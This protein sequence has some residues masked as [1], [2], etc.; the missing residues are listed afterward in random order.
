MPISL[1]ALEVEV[2]GKT[3]LTDFSITT[4]ASGQTALAYDNSTGVF[5]LTPVLSLTD[6]GVTDGL[7]GQ[8]LTTDGS[9]NFS[10]ATMGAPLTAY[11]VTTN[12]AGTAALSYN[13]TNGVFTYTPPDL[14]TL[15]ELTDIQVLTAAAGTSSLTYDNTNGEFIFTPP[16]L[17]TYLTSETNTSLAYTAGSQTLTYTDE[18][19]S[20]TNIDLSG[21]LD[22]TNIVTSV[23]TQTGA[24]VLD[25]LDLGITDGTTGQVLSTDGAGNF[26]FVNDAGGIAFTD[27]SITTA[28][29]GTA[30]LSYN[31][32]NGVFTYTPPD[33]SSYLTAETTTTLAYTSGTQTLTYTDETGS[34][35]NIDLSGLLDDTNLVTSVNTQTGAVVLGLLDLSISDGTAGQILSTDGAG[36]FSFVNDA[37]GIALTDLSVTTATAGTAAL[38]YD[39]STG[40]FTFTPEDISA[41]IELTDLSITTAAAG[42][43]A[44]AYDNSTGV[45]TYTP[46]DL[47]SYLTA[48]SDTLATITARGATTTTAVT[49]QD[50]SITGT[51]TVDGPSRN[52]LATANSGT[53]DMNS[54]THFSCTPAS[55]LTLT[56]TNITDGQSGN[57]YFDNSGGHTITKAA[58]VKMNATGL[59]TI[60][61]AGVFWLSYFSN[62]TDVLLS[63]SLQLT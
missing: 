13:N 62:G 58:H 28:T 8:F 49:L 30:A 61:T 40:V 29:A 2:D 42:T 24:V 54:N 9:G 43:A 45:F 25:L 27:L 33:L 12:S 50:V 19:G 48:E 3:E 57:I 18:T 53:F 1:A 35:T 21:L 14:S 60:S 20:A 47:S 32:T 39:N 15:I 16:D 55:G 36:N 38:V 34:A 11:S 26:S 59:T 17:S 63:N 5:N 46:P 52:A 31:N 6:I 22:D 51:M 4:S 37:S 10:F 56:F 41:K 44:L 23:N 7:S